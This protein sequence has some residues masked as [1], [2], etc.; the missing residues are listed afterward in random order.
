MFRYGG[1]CDPKVRDIRARSYTTKRGAKLSYLRDM[2]TK[3]WC[4][5]C[6][7][8]VRQEVVQHLT[9]DLGQLREEKSRVRAQ[10]SL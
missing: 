4:K 6:Y 7:E 3:R 5:S 10:H 1:A 9:P 8:I 2:A